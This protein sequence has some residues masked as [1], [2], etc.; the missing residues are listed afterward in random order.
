MIVLAIYISAVFSLLFF[1]LF[2]II[3]TLSLIYSSWMGSPYVPSKQKEVDTFLKEAHLKPN[4]VFIEL[5]CGDGRVVRTAV[6]KYKVK[7]IGVDINPL[8]IKWARF[9]ANQKQINNIDFRVEN[10]FKTDLAKADYVYIFLMP[11][12]IKKLTSKLQKELKNNTLVISHGFN[13]VGWESYLI[14][15]I[16]HTPFPTYFYQYKRSS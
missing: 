1:L 13:I 9:L 14:K 3:Y 4:K 7:G 12:P 16:P 11:D 10:I 6:S 8:I 2:M 15:K 5:G